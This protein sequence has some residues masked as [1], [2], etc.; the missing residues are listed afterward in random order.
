LA[1]L[2]TTAAI[3]AAIKLS[4]SIS[5]FGAC[6]VPGLCSEADPATG[7][8]F[9]LLIGIKRS[10][11][12]AVPS[13]PSNLHFKKVIHINRPSSPNPESSVMAGSKNRSGVLAT[14]SVSRAA[15]FAR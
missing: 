5:V 1:G 7:F 9:R 3:P 15:V 10:V 6:G 4:K 2:I 14:P 8:W 11:R 13:R 12:Q